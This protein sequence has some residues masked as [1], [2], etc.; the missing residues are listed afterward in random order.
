[1][2][3]DTILPAADLGYRG[4]PF[5][6]ATM[7]DQFTLA[8]LDRLLRGPERQERL[9][10]QV[11]LVSSHAP[12]VPV[13]RLVPWEDLG[14]GTVFNPMALA[15]DPPGVVWRDRDRV[16]DQYRQA[17]DYSLQAVLAYAARHAGDPPLMIV[18]GDHQ[19]A[20]FVA[21]DDRS[22]VPVHVIGPPELVDLLTGPEWTDGLQPAADAPVLPMEALR[23]L[24]LRT[25][26]SDAP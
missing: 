6:F 2:G 5:N 19:A 8:Q 3:F 23:D 25:Y 4:L 15:G 10:A 21:L 14:D 11:V 20:S 1:M 16:R 24:I 22:D 9:M 13:P 26:T 12:W 18:L 7:P 17:I